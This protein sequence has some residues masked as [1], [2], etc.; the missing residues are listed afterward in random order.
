MYNRNKTHAKAF[1][2]VGIQRGFTLT[3]AL[4]R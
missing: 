1:F 3:A 2:V 4:S